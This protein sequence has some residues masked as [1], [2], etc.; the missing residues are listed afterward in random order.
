MVDHI[1]NFRKRSHPTPHNTQP[2]EVLDPHQSSPDPFNPKSKTLK[3]QSTRMPQTKFPSLTKPRCSKTP[4]KQSNSD[5]SSTSTKSF[6]KNFK[7]LSSSTISSPNIFIRKF[8]P[9][10]KYQLEKSPIPQVETQIKKFTKDD[11]DLIQKF[12][13]IQMKAQME[14]IKSSIMNQDMKSKSILKTHE[15]K[16]SWKWESPQSESSK[17]VRFKIED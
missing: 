14:Y 15:K 16:I 5:N 11:L 13:A 6:N 17:T 4:Q 8:P 12:D 7:E 10:F 2:R 1:I 3:P 9:R